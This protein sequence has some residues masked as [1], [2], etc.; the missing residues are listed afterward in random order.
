MNTLNIN[1]KW[2]NKKEGIPF[3]FCFVSLLLC[4]FLVSMLNVSSCLTTKTAGCHYSLLGRYRMPVFSGAG[5]KFSLTACIAHS[6]DTE[7]VPVAHPFFPNL[8][9]CSSCFHVPSLAGLLWTTTLAKQLKPG[10]P[11]V[12]PFNHGKL[13]LPC[14][15]KRWGTGCP[16]LAPLFPASHVT[17]LFLLLLR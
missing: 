7:N 14:H 8:S 16:M 15:V 4:C 6:S 17:W 12:T 13:T 1:R 5:M 11:S 2:R 3:F 10:Q 9:S